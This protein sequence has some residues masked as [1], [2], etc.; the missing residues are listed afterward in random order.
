L[1]TPEVATGSAQ[2]SAAPAPTVGSLPGG[3]AAHHG[4]P[5]ATM[6]QDAPRQPGR[7]GLATAV[8]RDQPSG[9]ELAA[10]SPRVAG[11]Q[12]GGTAQTPGRSGGALQPQ[13]F[14]A[15]A[16]GAPAGGTG[17]APVPSGSAV[18]G[19]GAAPPGSSLA[20]PH[21]SGSHAASA[22]SAPSALLAGSHAGPPSVAVRDGGANASVP[23]ANAK[24]G[25]GAGGG[26]LVPAAL[27]TLG[28]ASAVMHRGTT[29]GQTPGADPLRAAAPGTSLPAL[30]KG[31][32][33]AGAV[34]ESPAA[35]SAYSNRFGP[36]KVQALE[37]FGGTADTERAVAAGLAYLAHLQNSDGS[38][39]NPSL[40]DEKYGRVYVGKT[41][42]CVLA[43]LGA[44]HTPKS[45]TQ[46]SMH[47]RNAV[48]HLLSL[49]D[50][51]GAFGSSSAYGHGI[52]T[53]ALCECYGITKDERLLRP[54]ERGLSWILDHQ[55]PRRDRK[56]RGGWGYFSPGLQPEDDY[57]RVSVSS[58]MV[59]ALESA[60]LSGID[61]P[62]QALARAREYLEESW[63]A[64]NGWFRYNQK[65]SRL[66]SAW[67]TLPASTPAGAFCLML[68]GVPPTDDRVQTAAA[69]TA[70]RR[71]VEYKRYS[72]DEF[73]LNGAGNVYFWYYGTLCCFLSGGEVWQRWNT[74][75]RQTLPA[76]Q[77]S[78]GSFAPI[79]VYARYAGDNDQ[80]RAYTTA[81]CVL[82]LEVYYRYFTPLLLG[83]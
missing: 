41:A 28:P 74:A 44:G 83:R 5:S 16:Q 25:G 6:L 70:E 26:G 65:P 77:S 20:M 46:Y 7:A 13:S 48:E 53:Y 11:N 38:W 58:W 60:R 37:K 78:D 12:G 62:P 43:F 79:D 17:N 31:R 76:A 21:G 24:A 14:P 27:P 22:A 51:D 64:E 15:L 1:H 35:A 9:G 72:D 10:A 54:V 36:A 55:G 42:L 30:A 56:N 34:A 57:A 18:A 4:T 49:Q 68:V 3:A 69:F 23:L 45:G 2:G 67:P 82:C 80:D 47:V 63:D 8:L 33:A 81:M 59:M 66:R 40:H 61:V 39:G 52:S 32:T 29:D 19:G 73:V 50:Q 71:P 75:L